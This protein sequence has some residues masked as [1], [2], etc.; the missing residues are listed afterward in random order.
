[1]L[2][3]AFVEIHLGHLRHNLEQ[4]RRRLGPAEPIAVVKADAYGHGLV[5]VARTLQEA[6][7]RHFAVAR[8]SEAVELREAGITGSI[9]LLGAAFP[10]DLAACV[11]H[12]VEVT[13]SSPLLAEAVCAAAP[14]YGPLRVHVK[15][16]TGMGRLGIWPE[17]APEI[18]RRLEQTPGVTLVG[19]CTHLATAEQPGDPFVQEQL[20]RFE[21]LWR[22]VGDAFAVRH[23]AN[24]GALFTLP[25][26]YWSDSRQQARIGAALYGY[27]PRP[28]LPGADELRPV[29]RFVACIVQVRTVPPGTTISYGRTWTAPGWRRIAVV[30]AGYGDG[31]PRR[32]SNRGQV[33]LHGHRFPIVGAVCMDMT[34]IDLGDP[35][36]APDVQEGEP[37]VFFG[38]GGPSIAEV[39]RWAETIPYELSCAAA[40]RVPRRYQEQRQSVSSSVENF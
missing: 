30:G 38:E 34:M 3:P 39:A 5:P 26:S 15:V 2:H 13:V 28:E 32:L 9:L 35:E 10:E 40:R 36:T 22:Q 11:A 18:I 37:V 4:V 24:S 29:M 20:E 19:L 7:I 8:L 6:G 25:S 21:Q 14:R 31:I 12:E 1:M 27:L 23:V 16:D 17:E 33:G